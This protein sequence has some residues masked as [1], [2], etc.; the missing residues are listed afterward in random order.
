MALMHQ[1]GVSDTTDSVSGDGGRIIFTKQTKIRRTTAIGARG[2]KGTQTMGKVGVS[3]K[4]LLSMDECSEEGE[5]LR[6]KDRHSGTGVHS[7]LRGP[8]RR[9][10]REERMHAGQTMLDAGASDAYEEGSGETDEGGEIG[11]GD[12]V[13]GSVV[14][15]VDYTRAEEKQV[16][17]TQPKRV[18]RKSILRRTDTAT[19]TGK[20]KSVTFAVVDEVRA[21]KRS[22]TSPWTTVSTGRPMET[23]R[24]VIMVEEDT[25]PGNRVAHDATARR[26]KQ[27]NIQRG[28]V[29]RVG[30]GDGGRGGH[31]HKNGAQ[32]R[33]F[34]PGGHHVRYAEPIRDDETS[35][36]GKTGGIQDTETRHEVYSEYEHRKQ[37]MERR[38]QEAVHSMEFESSG[39]HVERRDGGHGCGDVRR[40]DCHGTGGRASAVHDCAD[41][42]V[43]SVKGRARTKEKIT[44]AQ[45]RA[46]D[47]GENSKTNGIREATGKGERGGREKKTGDDGDG[48]RRIRSFAE[49]CPP[50]L[51]RSCI[52]MKDMSGELAARK[53]AHGNVLTIPYAETGLKTEDLVEVPHIVN[54]AATFSLGVRKLK[55]KMI[56]IAGVGACYNSDRFKSVTWAVVLKDEPYEPTMVALIFETGRVVMTGAR[57][58]E[59]ALLGAHALVSLLRRKTYMIDAVVDDFCVRN[60]VALTDVGFPIDLPKLA[61]CLGTRVL[62]QPERFPPARYWRQSN[63]RPV[64]L[65]NHS[66][67]VVTSGC[68]SHEDCM[69]FVVDVYQKCLM[70]KCKDNTAVSASDLRLCNRSSVSSMQELAQIDSGNTDTAPVE[71]I[72]APQ[73]VKALTW[74][75]LNFPDGVKEVD[76]LML[77]TAAKAMVEGVF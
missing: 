37:Y 58:R 40:R 33:F 52:S 57:T 9:R 66:G 10:N 68:S 41:D 27:G 59:Q 77:M 60:I 49:I 54:V 6:E 31:H 5:V 61:R 13:A 29:G 12:G 45:A 47:A 71:V 23:P 32:D 11:G 76:K 35:R 69:D 62:F 17:T 36:G 28:G 51:G 53:V 63:K 3:Q 65:I 74:D 42:R 21:I 14:G 50:L 15:G 25:G 19:G 16:R 48:K 38:I 1:A 26:Q 55:R 46:V 20:R 18:V 22:R 72:V 2:T 4:Q 43:G 70:F 44:Q 67:K 34:G 73:N 24:R 56:A 8:G 64:A 7:A 39:E 30:G 75:G